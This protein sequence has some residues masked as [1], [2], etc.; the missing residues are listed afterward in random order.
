[1]RQ[2]KR[3]K[4]IRYFFQKT[5]SRN[6]L[7]QNY[8]RIQ[9][10]DSVQKIKS[11][12]SFYMEMYKNLD[13]HDSFLNL[14]KYLLTFTLLFN[15]EKNIKNGKYVFPFYSKNKLFDMNFSS[16]FKTSFLNLFNKVNPVFTYFIYSVDKNI[17]KYS[18][19]KSGKYA[20]V[21]K[22][23]APYKRLYLV[24][25]LF[26][27]E[28][29]FRGERQFFERYLNSLSILENDFKN[30]FVYQSKNFSHNYVFKNF[31]KTLLL[32]LKTVS[33]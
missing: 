23:I 28:L 17:R 11:N 26:T 7:W 19:G 24:M 6:D 12:P 33:K 22:Y 5:I 21:W 1:M 27:K 14:E 25:R 13:K 8:P 9:F 3:D 16:F 30:S 10:D 29:K 2:G 18:R 32:S 4:L 31:K 20:F 15:F